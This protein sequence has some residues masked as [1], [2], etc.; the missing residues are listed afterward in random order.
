[1]RVSRET[2]DKSNNDS[3]LR[4]M[5]WELQ[6]CY[7]PSNGY[8]ATPGFHCDCRNNLVQVYYDAGMMGVDVGQVQNVIKLFLLK[9]SIFKRN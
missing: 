5:F 2:P 6:T 3:S 4:M 8:E 7:T 9:F 1:M